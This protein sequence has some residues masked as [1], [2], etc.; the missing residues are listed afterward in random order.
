MAVKCS[1]IIGKME[2]WAPKN[3]AESWDNVGLTVGN[4]ETSI[5][6]VLVALD[7]T[8]EVIEEA[9]TEKAGL[10]ITHHPMILFQKI[11]SITTDTPLGR[12]LY[13]L[14]GNNIA[15]YAAHTNLDIAKGGTN[16]VLAK[17]IGLTNVQILEETSRNEKGVAEGIGRMGDL[18]D[19]M[20]FGQLASLLRE[21]LGLDSIRLVGRADK[22][23]KRI[24]LCTGSGAEF[25]E[26]AYRQGADAY[27]T[28]DI[29]FHEAQRALEMGICVADAT[30]YASET[31]IVPVIA[32][33][34]KNVAEQS[35]W[36][37]EIVES[38]TD[39]QTFWH[40]V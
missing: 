35:K 32:Q 12:K 24:G 38:K 19:A 23:V 11:K 25:L 26:T 1:E 34:L 33:Y 29:K 21:R 27:I 9:I 6:K 3:L 4:P 40:Y 10:I 39:G 8:P 7:V 31:L 20:K 28:G 36:T 22:L 5:H 2:E 30:H 37:L 15:A 14:I 17:R 18:P 16:D 13:R